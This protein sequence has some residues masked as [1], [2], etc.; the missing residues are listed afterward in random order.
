MINVTSSSVDSYA[1]Q[2]L[3]E[4]ENTQPK[5]H[6]KNLSKAVQKVV[7]RQMI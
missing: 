7:Y 2:A 6:H 1:K 5:Q 4:L 3:V